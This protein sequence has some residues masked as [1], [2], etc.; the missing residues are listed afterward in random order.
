MKNIYLLLGT[1]CILFSIYFFY[2]SRDIFSDLAIRG[3]AKTNMSD[4]IKPILILLLGFF[5]LF[6]YLNPFKSKNHES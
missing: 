6:I 3:F 5:F 1:I 2:E 4:L